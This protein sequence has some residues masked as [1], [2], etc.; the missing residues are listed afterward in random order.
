[1]LNVVAV[2]PSGAHRARDAHGRLRLRA[3]HAAPRRRRPER[4]RQRPG[5]LR[6]S[7]VGQLPRRARSTSSGF[8]VLRRRLGRRLPR[9]DAR[10]DA[11]VRQPA[12]RA[13]RRRL[14]ARPGAAPDLDA[15]RP[16][17]TRNYSIAPAVRLEPPD[18]GAGLRPALRRREQH[19]RTLGTIAISANAISRFITFRVSK[20]SLGGTPG[21]GWAFTVVLTGQDGFSADQARGF[22]PTPQDFQFGVCAPGGRRPAVRRRS[23]PGAEGARRDHAAGRRPGNRARRTCS[24]R[25]CCTAS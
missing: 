12:R 7:D 19:R 1:M 3:G 13:A 2:S 6:L 24:A 8:Q 11:D 15:R 5:Q 21:P 25:S 16:S 14:R 23:E 22:Q 9:A 10:P 17:R 4:R 20:A 18:R